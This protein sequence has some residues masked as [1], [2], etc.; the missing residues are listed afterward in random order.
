MQ[1]NAG[2]ETEAAAK[3]GNSSGVRW[4]AGAKE[5]ERESERERKRKGEGRGVSESERESERQAGH[6]VWQ[7]QAHLQDVG[8]RDSLS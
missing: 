1:L 8:A 7:K 6:L 2:T 3:A 4:P 5:T